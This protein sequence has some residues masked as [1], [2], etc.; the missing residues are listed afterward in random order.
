VRDA[1][2][3]L[4]TCVGEPSSGHETE[5]PDWTAP[6]GRQR[7]VLVIGAGP[8]G[9]EAARVASERGH[10][11][12]V[13]ERDDHVGGNAV[14]AG[15]GAPLVAW[16]AAEVARLGVAIEL[17][18]G[19]AVEPRP[20]EVV[21]QCTG[22]HPGRRCYEVDSDAAVL[23]VADVRAG[24]T[25]LPEVG[26]VAVFDPI[27]GPIGVA[28]AEDLGD[29]SVLITQDNIAGNELSRTGD[30]APA[31][32]RLQQRGVRIERR[33]LLRAVHAADVELEDRFTGERRRVPAAALIDC[34]YRLPDA[35]LPEATLRAGDCV[36]PRTLHEAILEGR[37]AAH[38]I[39]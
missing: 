3:P 23:D 15:P 9:L 27:G 30:L 29:R 4:V 22:S 6:P 14:M 11:V 35:P 26:P 20:G 8:A 24:R 5:D 7:D 39:G 2:N 19:G 38:A 12:R 17:G 1:R 33:S 34:G 10:H 32:V 31:N 16:L 18:D 21:V 36:A 28:M 37:R 25:P 13:V